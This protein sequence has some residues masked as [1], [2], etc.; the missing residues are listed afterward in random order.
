MSIVTQVQAMARANEAM[1]VEL[2]EAKVKV[3]QL[4]DISYTM[5]CICLFSRGGPPADDVLQKA[6]PPRGTDKDT[7]LEEASEYIRKAMILTRSVLTEK[8]ND[9][10][11]LSAACQEAERLMTTAF[12]TPLPLEGLAAPLTLP[13]VEDIVQEFVPLSIN[14]RGNARDNEKEERKKRPHRRPWLLT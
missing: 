6:L 4:A 8:I 13:E 9:H 12:N 14:P 10:S 3:S 5:A 1:K 7:Y 2:R 11:A